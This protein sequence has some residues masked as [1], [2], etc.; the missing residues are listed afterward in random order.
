[1]RP[2]TQRTKICEMSFRAKRKKSGGTGAT[3]PQILQSLRSF[4]MTSDL[5][6]ADYVL[7]SADILVDGGRYIMPLG[8]GI[9][10]QRTALVPTSVLLVG[11][12]CLQHR[13]LVEGLT[14]ELHAHGQSGGGE[15]AGQGN[16]WQTGNAATPGKEANSSCL[17]QS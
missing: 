5:I 8:R 14:R 15:A 11:V 13:W 2:G 7:G 1:M 12:G 16:G 17:E 6:F 4:R 10:D 3:P 9:L